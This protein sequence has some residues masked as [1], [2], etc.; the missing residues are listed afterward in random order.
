M[1][2]A[3]EVPG[4]A[5]PLSESTLLHVLKSAASPNPQQIQ[6][7]TKQLQEWE[8]APGYYRHLQSVFID[9]SLPVEIRYLAII[10]VK[11]GIDRYWRKTASN[12]VNKDDKAI[13]RSRLIESGLEEQDQRLALQNALMIAKIVRHEFPSEW[14]EAIASVLDA[15]RS[16]AHP[17]ANPIRLPRTL[18][19]LLQITK[20]LAT[21]RLL[22]TR[23]SLN[24]IA[25]EVV[26]V[27]G[28]I[29]VQKVQSWQ[30]ALSSKSGDLATLGQEMQTSLL[31]IKTLRRLVITG[32]EFPNRESEV[33]Q[34]WRLTSS[35][36]GAFISIVSNPAAFPT[37][38]IQLVE[39]HLLQLSKLHLEMARTHPAAYVMLPDSLDLVRSYWSL[40]KQY[41]ETFGSRTAITNAIIGDNG[42][43]GE[44][45]SFQEKLSLKGLLLIRACIKMIHNPTQSFNYKHTQEKEERSSATQS[46]RDELLNQAFVQEVLEVVVTKFFVFRESDLREWEE[47]PEEWEHSMESES[48]GYEYSIRPCAEKVFLDLALN[49]REIVVEPLL[50][51][52][53]QVATPENANILLKDSVY[54]AVGLAAAVLHPHLDFN[55][56]LSS[57]LV[58]EIQKQQPGYNI[59]RRRIAILLG[60]WITIKVSEENRQL[61]YKIFQHLLDAGDTCNDQ[62]V[63]VTAGRQFKN[64]VDDW[65]FNAEQFLPYAQTTMS[66]LMQLVEEVQLTETK[67]ALLNTLSVIVERLEHHIAPYAEP[68]INL[69]PPLWDQSG[70]EHLMKQAILTILARLVNAMKAASGPF[71]SLVL[72]II[73]GAIEPES[74]TR[75]YLLDDAMDL[76]ASILLQTPAPASP[77]LLS[78]APYLLSVFE[79]DSENLRKGLEICQSYFLLAPTEMLS[80]SMR[81][82]LIAAL[83]S[84]IEGLKPD[85]SGLVNNLI[86]IIIRAAE[87]IGGEDAVRTV[88]GDFV[89]PGY[90]SKQLNGLRGSWIAHCTTGPRA[91][92]PA[93]DGV[94]ETDYFSVL[95]R[96]I[97]GS[98]PVFLQAVQASAPTVDGDSTL[99]STMKWLLEEWFSHFDNIG[100]PSHRKLMTMALTK[101]LSHPQPFILSQLQLLMNMWTDLVAELRDENEDPNA[102]SLVFESPDQLTALNPSVP[103]APEDERRRHLSY[104]DPVHSIKITEWIRHYLNQAMEG[105]GGQATFQNE[106]LINVD[107]DVVAAFGKLGIM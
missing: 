82:P 76:W 85:A 23:Q 53:Y 39:R 51:V 48:E 47:E 14:P 50:A 101:L 35:Q 92:A 46:L 103:E 15:L 71:H 74:E 96:I 49:Y 73:K 44:E 26:Q 24:A 80:D 17:G 105:C 62:V 8:R 87:G 69:L 67:M 28:Q 37:D 100:D 107:G 77:E 33:H 55:A 9:R 98:V 59:I 2:F 102:D 43:Q 6:T 64:V 29:Y 90:L 13:I 79:L 41:G 95:A 54:T 88:T 91:M 21:G 75:L 10:Q 63:R 30:N 27:L 60:Q 56:F 58:T 22:R 99:E 34:L 104:A 72:P 3:I 45:K 12:A 31:A 83:S 32:Y 70:E 19:I 81:K 66:R 61:V 25:P 4:E 84:L 1:S 68:I 42:D 106:W 57:T 20:E 93:I 11:N 40:V 94:V 16:S 65:E 97:M 89:D 36:V 7:G 86:E 5:N 78:L 52:F 18:L 38:M